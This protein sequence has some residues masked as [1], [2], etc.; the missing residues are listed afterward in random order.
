LCGIG[1][2]K[3]GVQMLLPRIKLRRDTSEVV[4][5]STNRELQERLRAAFKG[6]NRVEFRAIDGALSHVTSH[7]SNGP[8]V[9]IADLDGD[10]AAAI[11]AIENLRRHR[12]DGP[13]LAVSDTLDEASV[14]ALLHFRIADWLPASAPGEQIVQ[15]CERALTVKRRPNRTTPLECISF[16]PAGGG[17]GNTTLAIQTAFLLAQRNRNY[18]STCLVDLNFQLGTLADY[19]DLAPGFKVATVASAPERLDGQLLQVMLSRHETG[20][21]VLAP[22]RAPTEC[23]PV[24]ASVVTKVLGVASEMFDNMV[25]DLPGS[26]QPWTD[27]ILAGSDRIYVVTEFSVPA[28]RKA[29]ELVSALRGKL[30]KATPV[31]VIVNKYR[32]QLFGRGGLARRDVVELLHG[33]LGGFV[34]ED[35]GLVREAI[36]RG[37]PLSATNKANRVSRELNRIVGPT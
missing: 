12:F 26:W 17:V 3:N 5:V 16:L 33:D 8:A 34:P 36:N 14:R 18:Q 22:P 27:D 21:A 2:G 28:L 24:D 32:R 37:R 25:I 15:A 13:I 29:H 19:L 10:P 35:H 30:D 11:A 20:M 31:K 9:L 7:L 6:L 23:M 1:K 4:L